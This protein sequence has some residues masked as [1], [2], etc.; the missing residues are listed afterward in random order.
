MK[1][2]NLF[3]G[4]LLLALLWSCGKDDSPTPEPK[5]AENKAPKIEAQ[6]FTVAEDIS[7]ATTIGTVKATDEDQDELTFSI[8]AND[9]NLFEITDSGAL[10][11]ASGKSL[12]ASAKAQH[13]I[14][15]SVDDGED[16]ASAQMTIKVT[17]IVPENT[18]PEIQN[19]EFTVT[20]DIDDTKEIGQVEATDADGDTLTYE[21]TEND[22]DIFFISD[23]GALTLAEGKTLDYE[24]QTSH[25]ITVSVSDGEA[26]VTAM[27]TV[28]VEN[29][30]ESMVEDP[31]SFVTTWK[32]EG[33]GEKIRIGTF[34]NTNNFEFD[35]TIDWGD[36]T[37]E[38]IAEAAPDLFEHTYVT[39]GTYKVAIQGAFPYLNMN[40]IFSDFGVLE[41]AKLISI[42]QWGTI[43]WRRLHGAFSYCVNMVSTAT[44]TPDL[45]K[46]T[47]IAG[48]FAGASSFN[49][50]L[51][52][53]DVSNVSQMGSL[54]LDAKSFNSDISGW[55][56]AIAF[57]MT[58]MF[59]GASAFDQDLGGWN[60]GKVTSMVGMLDNSGMSPENLN[61]TLIGWADY[62]QQN[63][64]PLNKQL[65]INN[66]TF[67]GQSALL[68]VTQLINNYGWG[69]QGNFGQQCN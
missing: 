6:S 30:I 40:K 58:D 23:T 1:I 61:A 5:P 47:T 17:A 57:S 7:D 11:L 16:T 62:V 18:A 20:E 28:T 4:T 64:A 37:V 34:S 55:N 9:D 65:G 69:L 25:S 3:F 22:N 39:A 36:G 48:M 8:T 44:D 10:S 35:F 2:R 66:L 43:E 45:S 49:G 42:D 33:N 29:V 59:K 13:V 27:I 24:T 68:A 53:W 32:T 50:D 67:C 31:T 54:F 14:T 15:V 56:T 21:I 46:T 52:N 19:Q 60:I 38:E 41:T 26:S 63:N 12:D 51:S